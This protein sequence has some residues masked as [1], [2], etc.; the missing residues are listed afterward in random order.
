MIFIWMAIFI[1]VLKWMFVETEYYFRH[2]LSGELIWGD[3]AIRF[4]LATLLL[5]TWLSPYPLFMVV[6]I[7]VIGLYGCL[8]AE[9]ERTKNHFHTIILSNLNKIG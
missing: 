3:R 9:S 4:L 2:A 5:Y 1:V 7:I 6:V 8:L